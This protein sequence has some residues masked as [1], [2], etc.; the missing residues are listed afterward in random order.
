MK[1]SAIQPSQQVTLTPHELLERFKKGERPYFENH[2]D[3]MQGELDALAQKYKQTLSVDYKVKILDKE[4]EMMFE[5]LKKPELTFARNY[6]QIVYALMN[7]KDIKMNEFDDI[8]R[9]MNITGL[10]RE[11][12]LYINKPKITEQ[13]IDTLKDAYLQLSEEN[14][15][16]LRAKSFIPDLLNT[17]RNNNPKL[18]DKISETL[19][20]LYEHTQ[21]HS[22]KD[23]IK[24]SNNEHTLDYCLNEVKNRNNDFEY[25]FN[26]A[27]LIADR[28]EPRI[29][30]LVNGFLKLDDVPDNLKRRAILGAGK[31]RSE[32]NFE[33]IKKIALDTNETDIRKREFAIQSLAL[34]LKEKPEEV[35]QIMET[36]SKE[37]T[38]YAPLGRILKD[39]INGNY[40]GQTNRELNYASIKDKKLKNFKH[41]FKNFYLT[42]EPL[43]TKKINSLQLNTMAY[44][45]Q[46]K[47]LSKTRKYMIIGADDTITKYLQDGIGARYIFPEAIYNSGPFYDAYDGLNTTEINIMSAKRLGDK[48]HQNQIA[49]ET[50]HTLHSMFDKEDSKLIDTLFEK[51]TEKDIT[52]DYYAQANSHEYFAQGCDAYTSHYKPH[53]YLLEDNPIGHTVYELMDKDPDLFKFIKKV[54]KKYR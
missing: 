3:K 24:A 48:Y 4:R 29:N 23:E 33:I 34:Y 19:R 32:E 35:K 26:K 11:S 20:Y 21:H 40:H 13:H 38:I 16:G 41:N 36:I 54:L 8:L 28:K 5:E 45:N 9:L 44:L 39:K 31:F 17:Y 52:L 15:A 37:D 50:G 1:V 22:L 7:E 27:M 30:A 14:N 2:N 47:S 6:P 42:T 53:K 18:A 51:A 12:E 49:H 25:F 10:Q 46:L 43:S